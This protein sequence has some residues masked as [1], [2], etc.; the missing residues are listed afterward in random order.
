MLATFALAGLWEEIIAG[1]IILIIGWSW[2]R[3]RASRAWQQKRFKNRVV[4]ALNSLG[5][6]GDKPH[7]RLRT[8][9]ERDICSVLQNTS[10]VDILNKAIDKVTPEEPLLHFEADNAWYLLNAV[11]NQIAEQFA[12]GALRQD[13]GMTVQKQWYTFCYTFETEGSIRMHKIRVMLIKKEDLHNFPESGD[14]ALESKKHTT[15][16]K[17]LRYL[18]QQRQKFPHLFMDIELCQ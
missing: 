1:T 12:T 5:Q 18:K 4:L 13:M 2:G 7:L 9:F 17:T 11:L 3:W 10:M 15:R 6:E 8:L 16:V 14:I